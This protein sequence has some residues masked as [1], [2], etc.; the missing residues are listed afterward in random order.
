MTER[1]A[2][3]SFSRLRPD[4]VYLAPA[5]LFFQRI[6]AKCYFPSRFYTFNHSLSSA[7]ISYGSFQS[8]SIQHYDA[9][10]L[11]DENRLLYFFKSKYF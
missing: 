9:R 5:P 7:K 6:S 3:R 8:K 10:D 4:F 1:S 2:V 11:L